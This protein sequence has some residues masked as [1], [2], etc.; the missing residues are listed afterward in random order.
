M[1]N[2]RRN[3]QTQGRSPGATGSA[4]ASADGLL[5]LG[6]KLRQP[7]LATDIVY[8]ARLLS[9]LNDGCE[10]SLTLISAPAGYGKSTLAAQW[11]AAS[12]RPTAWVSLDE[13]DSDLRVFLSHVLA[14]IRPMLRPDPTQG[15]SLLEA[16]QLP[17]APVLARYL[18]DDL[19]A[20]TGPFLLVLDD[21]DRIQSREVHKLLVELLAH[22]H[23]AMHLVL[24]TRHDPPFPA[25]NRC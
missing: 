12:E 8:R 20:V 7:R 3:R 10:G 25:R 11:A 2:R 18:L 5:L 22:P 15:E 6:T 17:P 16:R 13:D 23:E 24:L 14:A 19:N 21:Y 4:P 1:P 9:R